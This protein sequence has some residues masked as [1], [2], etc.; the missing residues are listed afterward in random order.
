[1]T[2]QSGSHGMGARHRAERGKGPGIA[3]PFVSCLC[4]LAVIAVGGLG[5]M[6]RVEL[7]QAFA[8][9][10]ARPVT[11]RQKAVQHPGGTITK[12]FTAVGKPVAGGELLAT[13]E[14][15]DVDRRIE[16]LKVEAQAAQVRLEA[17]RREAQAFAVLQRESL[18]ERSRV[19]AL[20]RQVAELEKEAARVLSRIAEADS[21]LDLIEIRAPASGVVTSLGGLSE[22]RAITAGETLAEIGIA[23]G[24]M[25][26]ECGLSAD[27]AR[28][29]VKGPVRIWRRLGAWRDGAAIPANLVAVVPTN[30]AGIDHAPSGFVARIEID[31]AHMASLAAVPSATLDTFVVAIPLGAR[32]GLHLLDPFRRLAGR[33]TEWLNLKGA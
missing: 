18:V 3:V 33:A 20:E 30:A 17:V 10:D 7:E 4:G 24:A 12:V 31:A 13:V 11:G 1:M 16:Q 19:E 27:E 32:R 23:P 22:G 9:A 21:R 8:F 25:Q 14:P 6:S 26:L 29:A 2:R 15:G 5:V 28:H